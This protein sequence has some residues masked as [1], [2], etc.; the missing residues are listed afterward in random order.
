MHHSTMFLE[1]VGIVIPFPSLL[2][3]IA[4]Y[5]LHK[6]SAAV[7]MDTNMP[8]LELDS[9]RDLDNNTGVEYIDQVMKEMLKWLTLFHL[10]WFTF[11]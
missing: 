9:G 11:H 4:F 2:V 8:A 5:L 10:L 7:P 3:F 6:F 1:L